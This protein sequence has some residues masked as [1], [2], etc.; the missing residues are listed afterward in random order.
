MCNI[1]CYPKLYA[2]HRI[3]NRSLA[4]SKTSPPRYDGAILQYCGHIHSLRAGTSDPL[5][6]W[7][8]MQSEHFECFHGGWQPLPS[9][10]MCW[11]LVWLVL[12]TIWSKPIIHMMWKTEWSKCCV[13]ALACTYSNFIVILWNSVQIRSNTCGNYSEILCGLQLSTLRFFPIQTI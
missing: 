6:P 10:Q 4:D 8:P 2:Y 7:I 5:P 9:H 12:K 11:Q 1:I 13:L 3:R